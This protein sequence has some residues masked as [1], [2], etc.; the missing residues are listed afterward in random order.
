MKRTL[1]LTLITTLFLAGSLPAQFV[2]GSGSGY[3]PRNG[4]GYQGNGP[5][6]GTGYGARAGRGQGTGTCD[7]T[8]PKSQGRGQGQRRGGRR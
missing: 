1:F 6:D 3:G 4:T 8:G 7:Q 5:K 2:T